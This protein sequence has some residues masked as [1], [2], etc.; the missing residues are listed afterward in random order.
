MG[1]T[2]NYQIINKYNVIISSQDFFNIFP[3]I[4]PKEPFKNSSLSKII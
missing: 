3:Q 2:N 4:A 1:W